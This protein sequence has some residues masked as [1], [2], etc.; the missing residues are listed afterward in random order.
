MP[1]LGKTAGVRIGEEQR[2]SAWREN[3]TGRG[4]VLGL[5]VCLAVLWAFPRAWYTRTSGD[6]PSVWL[7]EI[8][9]APGWRFTAGQVA[10]SAE[11]LLAADVVFYGEYE[12]VDGEVVRLFSARRHRENPNEIGLFV[13]TPDRCWTEAGWRLEPVAEEVVTLVLGDIPLTVERRV[14]VDGSGARELVYFFG[15]VG[16]Q[17]L[18]YRLDH[19]LGVGQRYQEGVLPSAGALSA[20]ARDSVLWTRVWESFWNRRRL[21]GPKQFV[22]LS[23]PAVGMDLE[24]SDAILRRALSELLVPTGWTTRTADLGTRGVAIA[25]GRAGRDRGD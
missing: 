7:A 12:G 23:T 17:S 24:R 2:V 16:G 25:G 21:L 20:R 15:M 1:E 9:N 22:R 11:A 14:F 10:K 5:T 13:H 6:R 3:R 8:T 4:L 18:P 19:N